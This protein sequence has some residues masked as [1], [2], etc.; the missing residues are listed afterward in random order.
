MKKDNDI[1]DIL[2]T[3][4]EIKLRNKILKGQIDAKFWS[5]YV[6][7]LFLQLYL[8]EYINIKFNREYDYFKD[9][10]VNT[11]EDGFLNFLYLI[12]LISKVYDV[13]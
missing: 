5:S 3:E 11:L 6:T 9:F 10:F 12:D 7:C 13:I 4:L 8:I 2:N 1:E